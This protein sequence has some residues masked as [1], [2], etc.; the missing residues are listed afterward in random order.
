[1]HGCMCQC[2]KLHL[3]RQH[4]LNKRSLRGEMASNIHIDHHRNIPDSQWEDK[5]RKEK[6]IQ[7][8]FPGHICSS[9]LEIV[10][11][12]TGIRKKS[13]EFAW[14]NK[15]GNNIGKRRTPSYTL[16]QIGVGQSFLS[17]SEPQFPSASPSSLHMIL[18]K[19]PLSCSLQAWKNYLL[20][21]FESINPPKYEREILLLLPEQNKVTVP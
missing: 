3:P 4:A 6:D 15:H 1:M 19:E 12:P 20:N 8:A 18:H 17:I 11:G 10:Q 7:T 9:P 13:W 14:N 5:P 2:I 16:S 21:Q